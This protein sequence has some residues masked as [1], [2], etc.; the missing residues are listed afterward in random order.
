MST[1]KNF[2]KFA[3][4][5]FFVLLIFI[6]I[7]G[8]IGYLTSPPS[9]AGNNDKVSLDIGQDGYLIGT[10]DNALQY[11][12]ENIADGEVNA[13]NLIVKWKDARNIS[14]V[15]NAGKKCYVI[16]WKASLN[17]MNLDVE[18]MS[19]IARD[20]GEIFN[21]NHMFAVY[22]LQYNP[23]NNMVYGIILDNNR[24]N[25]DLSD[26]LYNILK[27]N[28]SDV[29]YHEYYS[30]DSSYSRYGVDTSPSTIARNDPDWY[31]DH[32]EYG[33]NYYIDDYLE[34]E[35]YD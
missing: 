17:D 35:G 32:Y 10:I 31:Y 21:Q 34:S 23:Q 1:L 7:V 22:Y 5:V 15:D 6:F 4:F 20:Y 9:I 12:S 13:S 27:L 19:K 26:L 16:V 14:Y 2:L 18:N 29:N 28:K 8:S 24:H 3:I 30:S 25:Y 33:D 11:K